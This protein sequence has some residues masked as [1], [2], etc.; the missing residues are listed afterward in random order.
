MLG[1]VICVGH[2]GERLGRVS[3]WLLV[4]ESLATGTGKARWKYNPSFISF[5]V[6][7]LI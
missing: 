1:L 5:L 2:G 6:T 3:V 7:V 4:C